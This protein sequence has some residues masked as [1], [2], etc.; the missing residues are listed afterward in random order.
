MPDRQN[1]TPQWP[2]SG[3]VPAQPPG[4]IWQHGV[5]HGAWDEKASGGLL[6]TSLQDRQDG[7]LPISANSYLRV[8]HLV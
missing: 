6:Y 3:K 8:Y 1:M 5:Q 2:F 7:E 4:R